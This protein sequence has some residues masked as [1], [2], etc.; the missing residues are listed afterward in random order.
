M[1][2]RVLQ[3]CVREDGNK[4]LAQQ[5][6]WRRSPKERPDDTSKQEKGTTDDAWRAITVSV[7]YAT[8]LGRN[9]LLRSIKSL[10]LY[11]SLL[12]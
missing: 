7:L 8:S 12:P 9:Q 11:V 3:L 4:A 10:V 5:D 6:S 2:C 1:N